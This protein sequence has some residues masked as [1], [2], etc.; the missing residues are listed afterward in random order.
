MNALA[1]Q[2][3]EITS[4]IPAEIAGR[5]KTGVDEVTTSGVAPG[6]LSGTRRPPSRC[7]TPSAIRSPRRPAGRGPGRGHVRP[8]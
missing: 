7:A 6:S 8:G 3:N 1:D 5:I 4:S 2:L